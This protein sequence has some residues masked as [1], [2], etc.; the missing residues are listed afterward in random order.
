L[1]DVVVGLH[2]LGEEALGFGRG[3]EQF[4]EGAKAD[5]ARKGGDPGLAALNEPLRGR[6]LRVRVH[7]ERILEGA[8]RRDEFIRDRVLDARRCLQTHHIPG[9]FLDLGIFLG[10]EVRARNHCFPSRSSSRAG[11]IT[12]RDSELLEPQPKLPETR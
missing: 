6:A 8:M 1:H 7:Q 2:S 10:E 9:A 12:Q 3:G 4:V 11:T 5:A